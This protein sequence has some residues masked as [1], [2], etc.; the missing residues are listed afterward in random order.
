MITEIIVLI[1]YI[2]I[3]YY[4]KSYSMFEIYFQDIYDIINVVINE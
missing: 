3:Y 2:Y 1:L 4:S